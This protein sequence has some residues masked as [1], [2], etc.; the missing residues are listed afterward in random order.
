MK[1]VD[2]RNEEQKKTHL[3]A[4]VAR[5]RSMSYWGQAAGGVSRCAWAVKFL[6]LDRVEKWVRARGDM[7][8]VRPVALA[9]YRAPKG[10]AHLHIYAVDQTHPAV[11]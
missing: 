3:W 8:Y 11:N 5:D 1:L 10:A 7:T 6:D 4:V 2:D 9:N